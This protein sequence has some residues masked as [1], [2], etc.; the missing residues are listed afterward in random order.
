MSNYESH[1]VQIVGFR[2]YWETAQNSYHTAISDVVSDPGVSLS[3]TVDNMGGKS[4]LLVNAPWA[5]VV[6]E[7]QE[8]LFLL[9]YTVP[10]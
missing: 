8:A 2:E 1:G 7:A 5:E 6:R 9:R 3:F 4:R 10:A